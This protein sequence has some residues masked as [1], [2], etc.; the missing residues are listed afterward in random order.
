MA[1]FAQGEVGNI[2]PPRAL[3][4]EFDDVED[5]DEGSK[6]VFKTRSWFFT[7]N[8]PEDDDLAQLTQWFESFCEK[9]I[10]QLE[11]GDKCGTPHFQ[12]VLYFKNAVSFN[13]MRQVHGRAS[14]FRTISW[15]RAVQYCSKSTTRVDGPWMKGV[16]VRRPVT[17]VTELRPWQA[18]EARRCALPPDDRAVR[19]LFDT[20][21]GTGK[22][23]FA[24]YMAVSHKSVA[25]L[26][27]RGADMLH[28]LAKAVATRE[29]TVVIFMFTRAVEGFVSY[30]TI[31]AIKDGIVCSGKYD[32]ELILMNSPHV[33]VLANFE[34]DRSR[35]SADRW[36]IVNLGQT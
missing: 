25:V 30:S 8:N 7:L 31:E 32:S 24:K 18:E 19:W 12:G 29:I 34:P 5:V 3:V 10:F 36:D 22:T 28:I 9:Y 1:Q 23:Q 27:G 6:K 4:R 20:E 2:R 13:T 35:L 17:V 16:N 11:V 21:G 15:V 14:W 33:L 26:S